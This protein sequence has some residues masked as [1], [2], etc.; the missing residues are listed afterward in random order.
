VHKPF[1]Q[2]L[3]EESSAFMVN[4]PEGT[5]STWLDIAQ[6]IT[7]SWDQVQHSPFSTPGSPLASIHSIIISW[8]L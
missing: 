7:S 6:W 4:D 1:K 8:L 5:K 3:R 2:Y